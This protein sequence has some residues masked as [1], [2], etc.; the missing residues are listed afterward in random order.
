MIAIDMEKAKDI[1]RAKIR[2]ARDPLFAP[3][4]VKF[5]RAQES[6][7]DTAAIVAQKQAL[8]N[9]PDDPRIAAAATLDDLKAAWPDC[10]KGG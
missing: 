8:R 2:A 3:L 5:Q 7:A 10:L 9:A 4:D 1:W 6:G